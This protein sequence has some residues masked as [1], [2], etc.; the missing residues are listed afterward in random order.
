MLDYM[1]HHRPPWLV[2]PPGAAT[3][4]LSTRV[5]LARNLADVPFPN[6]CTTKQREE[7]ISRVLEA[8]EHT[9]LLRN[10]DALMLQ[11]MN[12]VD[13][14]LLV[15]RHLASPEFIQQDLPAAILIS[16]DETCAVM[17]NEEDH[18]RMQVLRPELDLEEAW[19]MI[20]Q[21]DSE[22]EASLPYAFSSRY[23][24]LTA[25]P[26]N[27]GTGLRASVMLHLPALVHE[28][29]IGGVVSAVG[30]VGI[31]VRGPYGEHSESHGNMFQISNQVTLGHSEDD[32]VR[33]LHH[34][35]TRI[36]EH[37]SNLRERIITSKP[38]HIRN[39]VGR[40]YGTLKYA[41]ILTSDE[42]T[43]L[44]STLL[45]GID[46]QVF[47]NVDRSKVN[48]LLIDIQPAHLQKLCG[49]DLSTEERDLQRASVIRESLQNNNGN[50]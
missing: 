48:E 16:R 34:I 10:A 40:A 42:A 17:I 30:K 46:L 41:E 28:R 14:Q 49:Q 24:Y 32:I 4:V 44:L 50:H 45:M 3:I 23:G 39:D 35:V 12:A 2:T 6:R 25:C 47:S 11:P 21:F 33:Q 36:I 9:T 20:D 18:I 7:V 31:A 13:R 8:A 43:D 22:L 5:R 19:K 29:K 37:E 1:I 15:E 27:V 26:T 38:H